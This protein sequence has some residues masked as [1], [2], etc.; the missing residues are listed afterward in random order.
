MVW[1]DGRHYIGQYCDNQKHGIG[2]FSWK[3]GRCY[4][5]QWVEGK[6]HGSGIYTNAKG[7]TRLGIGNMAQPIR[8]QPLPEW[9]ENPQDGAAGLASFRQA[10]GLPPPMPVFDFSGTEVL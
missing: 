2:T 4:E 8:W 3:D 10:N 7:S 1:P 5:G 9:S 6:R